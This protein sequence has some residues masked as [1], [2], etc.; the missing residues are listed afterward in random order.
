[1]IKYSAVYRFEE[2]Q[3]IKSKIEILDKYRS[4]STIVNQ[5]INNVDVFSIVEE[6]DFAFVN[7]LKIVSGAIV[8]AHT[9]ELKKKLDETTS[10]LLSFAIIDIRQKI[11][12]DATE[13]IVP[14][15]IDLPLGNLK[16][17][18]TCKGRQETSSGA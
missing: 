7:Y 15:R 1:M 2:A 9:V 4:K 8:Q 16:I 11:K 17:C 6:K 3:M 5:K 14:I 18:G 10:D 12:S 13:I